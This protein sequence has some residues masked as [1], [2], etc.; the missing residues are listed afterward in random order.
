VLDFT[1]STINTVG[2]ADVAGSFDGI[3]YTIS[4][5]SAL[6]NA[7]H[8]T[9]EGCTGDGWD[10]AC[11]KIGNRDLWDVGFG[12]D[13]GTGLPQEVD[14][15]RAVSEWVEVRFDTAVRILGFA[16]MLTY[17]DS[18]ETGGTETV[19]LQYSEDGGTTWFSAE[20]DAR[21]DD[22]DPTDVGDN[23]FGTVGLAYV[24]GLSIVANV[25]R[26]TAG[27]VSPFDNGN[28]NVTAAGLIVAPVPVPASFPLLVAGLGALGFAARRKQRKAA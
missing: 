25:V 14:T 1:S 3:G 18:Q 24:K 16:G 21:N 27:G 10:F 4:G 9:S 15:I 23:N 8:F 12:V 11:S 2:G 20:A 13:S 5:S 22:N 19:V 17:L 7:R 26:F 6:S 28:N